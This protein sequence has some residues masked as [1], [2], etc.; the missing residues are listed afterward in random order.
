MQNLGFNSLAIFFVFATIF[1]A[2]LQSSKIASL[3]LQRLRIL[4]LRVL[5]VLKIIAIGYW[6]AL[7]SI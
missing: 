4:A 6:N 7:S 1:M 5:T 3:R 2:L